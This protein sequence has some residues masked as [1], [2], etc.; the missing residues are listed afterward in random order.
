MLDDLRSISIGEGSP[1]ST[2]KLDHLKR[3]RQLRSGPSRLI[4]QSTSEDLFEDQAY[5]SQSPSPPPPT[6]VS[7][8]SGR[9]DAKIDLSE[10]SKPSKVERD[11]KDKSN[12]N[13]SNKEQIPTEELKPCKNP[14]EELKTALENIKAEEWYK[15]FDAIDSVRRISVH[16]S[17]VLRDHLYVIYS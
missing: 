13:N 17:E 10:E 4:L 5:I 1:L 9:P 16:H 8:K 6:A 11:S 12:L 7:V 3:R 2:P 14:K 15:N